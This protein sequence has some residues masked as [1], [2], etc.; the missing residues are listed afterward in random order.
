MWRANPSS[1][2]GFT[3]KIEVSTVVVTGVGALKEAVRK[4][5]RLQAKLRELE[6]ENP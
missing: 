3:R 5:E 1:N 6:A 2:T 4:L